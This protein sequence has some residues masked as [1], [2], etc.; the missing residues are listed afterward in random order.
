MPAPSR[1]VGKQKKGH[2]SLGTFKSVGGIWSWHTGEAIGSRVN[3]KAPKE[4]EDETGRAW[5][6]GYKSNYSDLH[7]TIS[8][9]EQEAVKISVEKGRTVGHAEAVAV[10]DARYAQ[11]KGEANKAGKYLTFSDWVRKQNCL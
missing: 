4:L 10:L 5:R 1:K 9:V 3:G 6:A 7:K 8:A 11:R 2:P